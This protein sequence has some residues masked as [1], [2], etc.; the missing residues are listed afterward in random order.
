MSEC[1]SL[2]IKIVHPP[3]SSRVRG[4]SLSGLSSVS[5][6]QLPYITIVMKGITQPGIK[7]HRHGNIH[8]RRDLVGSYVHSFYAGLRLET[9]S[10]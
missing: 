8:E 1:V 4:Q 7:D 3:C 9:W 6:M 10:P 5:D 2:K